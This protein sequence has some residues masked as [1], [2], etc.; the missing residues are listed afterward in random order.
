MMKK[1]LLF[2]PIGNLLLLGLIIALL[3]LN[4]CSDLLIFLLLVPIF[5]SVI[6]IPLNFYKKMG[7]LNIILSFIPI[8]LVI[9]CLVSPSLLYTLLISLCDVAPF[10]PN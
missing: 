6:L 8:L 4:E 10:S 5:I 1:I 7:S 2:I 9:L 3:F